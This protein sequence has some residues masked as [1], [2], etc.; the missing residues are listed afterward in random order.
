MREI[1][2]SR[3]QRA[4]AK[5][6]AEWF[7]SGGDSLTIG[8]LAGTGKT[9]LAQT[10]PSMLGLGAS[11]VA[12]CAYTGKA[13]AVLNRRL[14]GVEAKTFHRL[15]YSPIEVHC[16]RCPRSRDEDARCHG[17]CI[18][19]GL[20]WS[21]TPRLDPRVRLIVV[22]EASMVDE[23]IHDDLLAFGVPVLWI[24]DHG[25][26]PP[27]RGSFNL[28]ADPDLRLE[29]IHRQVADSPI[30]KMAMLARETGR[31]PFGEYGPGVIK[32]HRDGT[33]DV[34][35]VDDWSS[36]LLVLCGFN[37]TRVHMNRAIRMHR[38]FPPDE[39]VAGD[40]VICLRNNN[41]V[42]VHNGMT[43][44][45]VECA[46]R[47]DD[48]YELRVKLD[49]EDREYCRRVS[50]EQFNAE[51]TVSETPRKLDLWDFG[52]CMTVHKAQGSE[53][54]RVVLMEER[55]RGGEHARWLYTGIT[56]AKSRLEVIE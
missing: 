42:G 51:K 3:E 46:E 47:G 17:H 19:C 5:H 50:R 26:L 53:A 9:T 44:T 20:E 52:Y 2:L 15:M 7:A 45:V 14:R 31:V 39:P 27:V 54:E 25:Q 29:T 23:A 55:L 43:G 12:Y 13:V 32:R 28:M 48:A 11:E 22:D 49:G 6:V 33:L 35:D 41:E 21:R 8:G 37:K 4:V 10:L 18:R 24:G 38:G 1:K 16:S 30:L 36:D 40:R 56:R 34:D